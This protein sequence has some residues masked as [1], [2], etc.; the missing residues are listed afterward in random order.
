MHNTRD[1]SLLIE[2]QPELLLIFGNYHTVSALRNL[3][4]YVFFPNFKE[5]VKIILLHQCSSRV[6]L[7]RINSVFVKAKLFN[8]VYIRTDQLEVDYC[9]H[10]RDEFHG[11]HGEAD[12]VDL[13]VD[14]TADLDGTA[15]HISFSFITLDGVFS[16]KKGVFNGRLLEW[17]FG[18]IEHVNGTCE[19][20]K[21]VCG[22]ESDDDCSRRR[23]MIDATTPFDFVLDALASQIDDKQV[24]CSMIPDQ[25][26]VAAPRGRQF[27]VRELFFIPFQLSLWILLI[28]LAIAGCL[29][30]LRFPDLFQNDLILMPLCGFE[31]QS[32]N[33]VSRFEKFI[34]FPT[35]IITFILSSA[36]ESKII[37]YMTSFPHVP[38][39]RTFE[40]LL[41]A[42]ITV[43]VES[44]TSYGVS[45]LTNNRL[46]YSGKS[47]EIRYLVDHPK[48]FDP[49]TKLTRLVILDRFSM[50][51]FIPAYFVGRRN[52]LRDDFLRSR[53]E[54]LLDA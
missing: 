4:A 13:F 21:I 10:Y 51:I 2:R 32:L 15:L 43:Q 30:M 31:R 14:Q 20:H 7:A 12:F 34:L 48:S 35:I 46:G 44:S 50:G 24:L 42:G 6:E 23:Y 22:N 36:Y 54:G 38:S 9:L 40:D 11:W 17:V 45:N 53:F 41:Q 26:L 1:A 8:V 16:R 49:R 37:A 29:L 18:T 33:Q 39:P 3:F 47:V 52:P 5:S 19:I 28:V 25:F 27:L